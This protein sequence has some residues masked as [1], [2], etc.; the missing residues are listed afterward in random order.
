MP[1]QLSHPTTYDGSS[2][3][4]LPLLDTSFDVWYLHVCFPCS[5]YASFLIREGDD[6]R[7]D[8]RLLL[9]VLLALV[10][11]LQALAVSYCPGVSPQQRVL[12]SP[13][14][15]R[16]QFPDS[17][18]GYNDL[19]PSSS[20]K[21]SSDSSSSSSM[22]TRRFAGRRGGEALLRSRWSS[23]LLVGGAGGGVG[24]RLRGGLLSTTGASVPRWSASSFR[25]HARR[26]SFS[27]LRQ[28]PVQI[29]KGVDHPRC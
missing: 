2:L 22:G 14:A 13:L 23:V 29:S 12:P 11:S 7:Y 21:D 26:T 3:G 28:S 25:S 5:S 16:L 18:R 6:G 15:Y 19:P 17:C 8:G 20:S 10:A 27:V 9:D 24:A 1:A 4:G